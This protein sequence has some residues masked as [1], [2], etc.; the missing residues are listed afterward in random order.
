MSFIQC[1]PFWAVSI[2]IE[3]QL[4]VDGEGEAADLADRLGDA[5][6]EVGVLVDEVPRA[7]RAAGLLV[8]EEGEHDVAR[9][10]AAAAQPVAYDRQRHRVHVLHVDGAAAPHAAV[11]D[12]AGE[13][14]VGPV[15]RVGRYDVGVAVDEQRG[16]GRVLALDPGHGRGAA[17]VRLE[18]LRLEPHLGELLGDVLG[19]LALARARVVAVVAGVDPD[20]LAAEVDD[21]VLAGDASCPCSSRSR[22]FLPLSLLVVPLILPLPG[23][24]PQDRDGP[25]VVTAVA[26]ATGCDR[27]TPECLVMFSTSPRRKRRATDTLSGWRNG[28]RASL[29]C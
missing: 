26:R 6:E 5:L 22:C 10:L 11:G 12:L 19:G 8:G 24:P 23:R 29:R 3:P 9:G 18:D 14:V 25:S 17:R 15:R 21:L 4:L 2:E 16:P 7:V 28:R 13:G 27:G 1:M 20:Q